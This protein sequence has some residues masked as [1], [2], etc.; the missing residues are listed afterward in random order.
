MRGMALGLVLLLA[1]FA[2]AAQVVIERCTV[3]SMTA[4]GVISDRDVTIL[5]DR[6]ASIAP[7]DPAA[8]R[9]GLRR[10]DGR[11]LFL[12][13]GLVEMHGHIPAPD[14]EPEH[15]RDI[16]FMSVA[17]GI[18]TV[19]G[20]LGQPGQLAMRER[21][22][23]EHGVAPTLFL[24][25]PGFSRNTPDAATALARVDR[26]VAEGWDLL[27]IFPGVPLPAFEAIIARARHH[28]IPV[29][30]H[31]PQEVGIE[32]ALAS[33]MRTIEHLDGYIEALQGDAREVPE[34]ELRN[35]AKRTKA[36]GVG[37]VPTMDVWEHLLGVTP[38]EQLATRDELA[39]MPAKVRE[40]WQS[41]Y[42]AERAAQGGM[43]ARAKRLLGGRDPEMVVRNRR[44]L[45]TAM[46]AE[47]VEILF[48]AD[49]PQLFVVPGF[50]AYREAMAMQAAG[51]RPERILASATAAPGAYFAATDR[52]GVIDAGARADLVLLGANPRVSLEALRDIRGVV[53]R[54]RWLGADE[55]AAGLAEIRLRAR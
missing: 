31:V 28:G 55:L 23:R 41:Q 27:K 36:A 3:L 6:I 10:I 42:R 1:N 13:P 8:S 18:T 30:G 7:H 33:G 19:R 43:V 16:L 21:M 54:G 24:A 22:R 52:F 44:K 53:L 38:L 17:R 48:G 32:R 29:A 34:A 2:A 5:G 46:D 47:G 35:V 51:M 50:S 9:E 37:V 15:A 25:S 4:A 26:Q 11:G 39:Y 20:M 45:L 14:Q 12:L 40:G 49:T